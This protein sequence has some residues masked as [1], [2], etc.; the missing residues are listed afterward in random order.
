[1]PGHSFKHQHLAGE[2]EISDSEDETI[3]EMKNVPGPPPPQTQG[4]PPP[5][6]PPPPAAAGP[7]PVSQDGVGHMTL[8]AKSR[9][10]AELIKKATLK[11]KSASSA[12][13]IEVIQSSIK[14]DKRQ[15]PQPS[16]PPEPPTPAPP[17]PPPPPP[18]PMPTNS[19]VKPDLSDGISHMT[20]MSKSIMH[21]EL[22][23]KAALRKA[24]PSSA[25]LKPLS[26]AAAT[27]T[28]A[29]TTPNQAPPPPPP[30]PPPPLAPST[31]TPDLSDGVAHMTAL[32]KSKM[33]EELKLKANSRPN[34]GTPKE[35]AAESKAQER[36][37]IVQDLI[38][39]NEPCSASRKLN[40]QRRMEFFAQ[41]S[42]TCIVE[43]SNEVVESHV[44][45]LNE[46]KAT[47]DE[48]YIKTT[49]H[50][51]EKPSPKEE[52]SSDINTKKSC[53]IL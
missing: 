5:P 39:K 6:P 10:H 16:P 21:E 47:K 30:P 50:M 25:E 18:A 31:L 42:P 40:E 8:M 26:N 19:N 12:A 11:S 48:G 53:T 32:S 24:P 43:N 52:K 17:P 35:Q 28:K 46:E 38:K 36:K 44:N 29:L 27:P 45:L 15:T 7:P 23:S 41:D 2:T 3:L 49:N 1:V 33:H 34:L 37:K 13:T 4:P 22:K 14:I 20:A 51:E 9:M